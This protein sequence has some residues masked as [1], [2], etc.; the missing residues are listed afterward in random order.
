MNANIDI[1][2]PT[3]VDTSLVESVNTVRRRPTR[4]SPLSASLTHAWRAL[5]KIKHVPWQLL[6]VTIFPVLMTVMFT[7]IF[8][9]AIAGSIDVYVQ[10]LVPGILVLTVG[11]ISMYTAVGL[12]NDI[13]KG[14]FDRFRALAFWRP[15]VLVGALLGDLIRYSVAITVVVALGLILGFRPEAGVIGV[16]LASA[17]VL[18]F[19]FSLSW[20]WTTIG[21]WV[22]DPEAVSVISS[23]TTFPLTFVS[24]V[25]VDPVTMPD[26]LQSLVQINPIS[27]TATAVRGLMHG[28]ATPADIVAVLISCAVLIGIFAPLTMYLYN[29]KN[30]R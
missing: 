2:V 8:G 22:D 20:I 9:G 23:L 21:L 18:I 7:Y 25:F 16:L 6:D 27:L 28:T 24:N 15:A 29:N 12:N 4:P 17:I 10:Q 11:M 26:A 19:A 5:L 1:A 13:S 14:I 3:T 30:S